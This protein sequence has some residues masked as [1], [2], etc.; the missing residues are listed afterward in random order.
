[1]LD[2]RVTGSE[3]AVG[4]LAERNLLRFGDVETG[5]LPVAA[6]VRLGQEAVRKQTLA[7][8]GSCCSL[9]DVGERDLLIASH[10]ARWADFAAGRGD[11]RNVLCLC[12]MH[13]A[14]F[15]H[16]YF[17][18]ADDYAVLLRREKYRSRTVEMLLRDREA[19]RPPARF[20]PSPEYL[21][22]HR[23]RWKY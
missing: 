17:S 2:E 9:C 13:D 11:L 19:I 6:T 10:I 7:N 23:A 21:A 20:G 12:R 8:Y 18:V 22:Q 16:G 5:V 15:E 1:M 4:L 3:E 14:L